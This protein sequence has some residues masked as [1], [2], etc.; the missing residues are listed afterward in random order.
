M[1]FF[2]SDPKSDIWFFLI[3]LSQLKI[4]VKDVGYVNV[5]LMWSWK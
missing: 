5:G 4:T 1:I 3:N 2:N